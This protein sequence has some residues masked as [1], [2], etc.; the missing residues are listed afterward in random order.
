MN[1][2]P[3][4]HPAGGLAG[5]STGLPA[6]LLLFLF[7]VL[8]Q[9]PGAQS[10]SLG[11]LNLAYQYSPSGPVKFKKRLIRDGGDIKIYFQL[12]LP[13]Y[14]SLANYQLSTFYRSS[15]A[16]SSAFQETEYTWGAVS[17]P[18]SYPVLNGILTIE[19]TERQNILVFQVKRPST[20][21]AFFF[22]VL[23]SE[24]SRFAPD[25][26]LPLHR[27]GTPL[28]NPFFSPR[29]SLRI[30]SSDSSVFYGFYYSLDFT[31]ATPPM[32]K[33]S[34]PAKEM[35][36]DS[37]FL[38]SVGQIRST[39]PGLYL[40]QTDSSSGSGLALRQVPFYYPRVVSIDEVIGP[41]R[42]ISSQEEYSKLMSSRTRK[43]ALDNFLLDI[44]GSQGRAK[45]IMQNYFSRVAEANLMFT[46]FKEGWKTDP[47]MIYMIFGAPDVVEKTDA[48]ENW[49]YL[50]M[51]DKS[52]LKFEF[53]RVKNIFTP[54]YLTLI[55]NE[56]YDRYWFRFV[57][58]WRKGR[59]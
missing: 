11:S 50:E 17:N 10:Q 39:K 9:S 32:V 15:Y 42:Y 8:F 19:P 51:E 30:T 48:G 25:A 35:E 3:K 53:V 29:D 37:T 36:I 13:D 23:L 47:G 12:E 26:L 55:R 38:S 2:V 28:L 14:D 20:Q 1:K 43:K 40:F 57:D 4:R 54:N 34:P 16:D 52:D 45:R 27:S 44:S 21:K 6:G 22:D 24:E 33:D 46:G 7:M 41:L 5:G 31:E 18:S 59:I 49:S 56:D 58:L